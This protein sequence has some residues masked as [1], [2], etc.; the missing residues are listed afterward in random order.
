MYDVRIANAPRKFIKR[1]QEKLKGR[2]CSLFKILSDNP[3]PHNEFDLKKLE[4]SKNAY[5]IRISSFRVRYEVYWKE[6]IVRITDIE[7]RSETTYK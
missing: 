3:I 1:A 5:R 6:K 7:K 4:G 2:I